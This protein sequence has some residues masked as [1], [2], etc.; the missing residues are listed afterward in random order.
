MKKSGLQL[1][2]ALAVI[3]T[4]ACGAEPVAP[5]GETVV[6][7]IVPA[8]GATEVDPTALI[9][10]TFSH[11]MRAGTEMYVALRE[12]DL[13][14]DEVAG[15]RTWSADHTTLTFAP[16]APLKAATQYVLH[17]GGNMRDEQGNLIRYEQCEQHGGQWVTRHMMG[18]D[19]MGGGMAGL[20]WKHPNGNYGMA[21]SF[22]TR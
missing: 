17:M 9:V 3:G 5:A 11:A 15:D 6:T 10:L 2:L 13:N 8:G 22:T 1:A 14:G 19:M 7:S 20:G 21:F 4:L 18:G 12:G 16:H